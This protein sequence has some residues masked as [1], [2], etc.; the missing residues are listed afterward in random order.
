M[1]YSP[2]GSSIYGVSQTRILQWVARL[3]SGDLPHPGIKPMSPEPP[4]WAGFFTTAPPGKTLGIL[5]EDFSV[6]EFPP[7][8]V[9]TS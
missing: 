7:F 5:Y 9:F 1:N 4:A 2:P 6:T 3:S 8:Q